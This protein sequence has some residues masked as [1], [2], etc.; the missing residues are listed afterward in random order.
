MYRGYIY[1]YH[2]YIE[3]YILKRQRYMGRYI[4]KR[5]RD[6]KDTYIEETERLKVHILKR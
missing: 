2:T 4:H 6:A 5:D 3:I 1:I